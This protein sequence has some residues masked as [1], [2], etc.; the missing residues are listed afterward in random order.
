MSSV[1]LRAKGRRGCGG[2]WNTRASLK[3]CSWP[4][5]PC[6]HWTIHQQSKPIP[7]R[8]P[9]EQDRKAEQCTDPKEC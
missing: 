6:S 3:R 9:G 2:V 7:A 4:R 1:Q 5:L 8:V